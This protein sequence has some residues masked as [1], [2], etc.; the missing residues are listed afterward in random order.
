LKTSHYTAAFVALTLTAGGAQAQEWAGPYVGVHLGG[1]FQSGDN[2]ET[3]VFDRNLDGVFNESVT[4]ALGADAFSPGFC[5][6][7]ATSSANAAC[8]D[9]DE[10]IEGG[11]RAGYD[12]QFGPWVLGVVGEVS[13]VDATDSVSGFSTTPAS[14]T[15][16]REANWVA[17]ARVRAGF[18]FGA[19]LPYVTAGVARGD[20]DHRFSTSNGANAFTPRGKDTLNGHQIGAGIE[21]RMWEG[22]SV[23]LEYIH[24]SLKDEDYTVR[25]TQG[26]APDTN[27]FVLA[28]NTTGTDIRRSDQDFE[29][30]AVRLT[31]AYRF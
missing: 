13:S 28:P 16:T 6:G 2:D 24:T 18:A 17:A 25:V 19:V 10:G 1:V 20:V 23:G 11:V 15:F 22:W 7:A 4:T 9:D 5:G 14:Y 29:F 12:W 30:G 31:A 3:L 8:A 26:T 21:T 27:P